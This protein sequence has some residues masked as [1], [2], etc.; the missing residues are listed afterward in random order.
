MRHWLL[1]L[2]LAA[3]RPPEDVGPA[4]VPQVT[5]LAGGKAGESGGGAGGERGNDDE[6]KLSQKGLG[7]EDFALI[8]AELR[9][10]A[11]QFADD[12]PRK[13]AVTDAI[14]AR[15]GASADWIE[16]VRVHMDSEPDVQARLD[17]L[18]RRRMAQVCVDG[19]LPAEL[20]PAAPAAPAPA[21]PAAPAD[22][23]VAPTSAEPS[24]AAPP[25]AP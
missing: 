17:E 3:C 16:R 20:L 18:V 1:V 21:N 6:G 14:I 5:D 24:P 22:S 25:G 23:A 15:Y 13:Q 9:C 11:T 7:K 19:K 10:A 8:E 12:A 4:G 2:L